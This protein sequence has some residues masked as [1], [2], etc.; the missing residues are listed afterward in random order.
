MTDDVVAQLRAAQASV[1]R[2][3][4]ALGLIVTSEEVG[5]QD[6]PASVRD[7]SPATSSME[8][9]IYDALFQVHPMCAKCYKQA[10]LEL[11]D[12]TRISWVGTAH[13][14]REALA[15]VLR[16]LAPDDKVR[17]TSWYTPETD[18]GR[19]TH[20]QRVRYI[21]RQRHAGKAEQAVTEQVELIEEL[22]A[23]LV[24]S[25]Y[26]RASAAAHSGAERRDVRRILLYF[27]AFAHDLLDL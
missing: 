10:Y 4:S 12:P 21:L 13:L 27:E 7:E 16:T 1:Q 14:I 26:S 17:A 24:R 3:R 25:T 11:A 2:L 6:Q 5:Q 23:N 8:S 22:I 15:T 9:H 20:K 19:P 18:D